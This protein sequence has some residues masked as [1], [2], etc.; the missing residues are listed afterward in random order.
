[1]EK[2][3]TNIKPYLEALN[4]LSGIVVAIAAIIAL[5]QIR[6]MKSDMLARS[7]RAAKEKALEAAFEYARVS[8]LLINSLSSFPD[9]VPQSYDGPIGDF[10][11]KSIPKEKVEIAEERYALQVVTHPLNLLDG[12]AAS[13]ITGVADE[14]TSFPIFGGAFCA[15]IASQ[16]DVICVARAKF[17]YNPLSNLVSLYQIWSARLSKIDL[18]KA[19]E[20]LER[21]IENLP[22]KEIPPLSPMK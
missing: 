14:K 1:M 2:L 17:S 18:E 16:Y 11:I 5:R 22:D 9:E 13:F 7:E 6:L 4:L 19:K 21:Q 8:D 3:I 20:N 15:A 10:S 12:I